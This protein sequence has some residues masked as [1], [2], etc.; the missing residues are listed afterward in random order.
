MNSLRFH[1]ALTVV[2]GISFVGIPVL[3]GMQEA[4]KNNGEE[5]NGVNLS[6]A[7]LTDCDFTQAD[8]TGANFSHATLRRVN[9]DRAILTGANF[10]HARLVNTD[11][12]AAADLHGV[13]LY[14][15]RGLS[16]E[17]LVQALARGAIL[18]LPNEIGSEVI[19]QIGMNLFN[20]EVKDRF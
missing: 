16:K 14:G 3:F 19:A 17:Q 10:S 13:N 4:Y 1:V 18:R 11:L 20:Y 6:H 12:L 2:L 5:N 9:F 8:V 15:V 7:T